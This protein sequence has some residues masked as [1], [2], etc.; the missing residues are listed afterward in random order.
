M[1]SRPSFKFATLLLCSLLCLCVQTQ[2]FAASC[3][4]RGGGQSV[5]VLPDEQRYQFGMTSS[6]KPVQGRFDPYGYYAANPDGDSLTT[7]TMAFGFAYRLGEGWQVGV[8]LPVVHTSETLSGTSRTSTALADPTVEARYTLWEDLAFLTYRPQL[9]LYGGVR[10]PT[11]PSIYSS[12]DQTGIDAVSE[13]LMVGYFG[14]NT[15]KFYRPFKLS[16]DG[17]FFYPFKKTVTEMHGAP[18]STSYSLKS[19]NRIQL[20]EAASYLFN[21]RWSTGAG[22]KQ[23]WQ[24]ATAIDGNIADGSAGRLFSSVVSVN[25]F[26]NP[27]WSFAAN[28]ETVFP[29]YHYLANQPNYQA[30]SL[31]A[32][33]GG[34]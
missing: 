22:L 18:V 12:S 24:S 31:A 21:E 2:A 14:L 30:I 26:Y 9:S 32:N 27:A 3:C 13:G 15:S 8:S 5:C 6:Y 19:G 11:G 20:V 1:F 10:I 16:F 23:F 33:Y 17:G 29:F 34:I 7:A 25:Y 28:Y 4:A